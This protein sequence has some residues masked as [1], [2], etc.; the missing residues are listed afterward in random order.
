MNSHN[1]RL[2]SHAGWLT[3]ALLAAGATAQAADITTLKEAYKD[4][5]YV[6]VA[7]NRTIATGTAV[8]ADNVNRNM[9]Q[10]V[11]DTALAIQ[12]FNQIVP[13]NDTKWALIHPN[14]GPDGYDF[15]PADAFVN[16]GLSNKMYVVGHTLV[17]HSQTPT[18]VFAGTNLPPGVTNTPPV[19]QAVPAPEST[20]AADTNAP[21][22]RRGR[23][24][25]RS[26]RSRRLRRHGPQQRPAR[27][28]RRI[29]RPPA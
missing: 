24:L 10:V 22:A 6:G 9:D 29:A 20:N 5:F 7:I 4:H 18:W 26:W 1:S 19:A 23:R 13:E 12:Q 27:F 11:K 25:R 3:A 16:F 8:R 17:W 15:P 2:N 14:Q 28:Q 21:G